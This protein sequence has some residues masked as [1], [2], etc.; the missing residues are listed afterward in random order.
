MWSTIKHRKRCIVPAEGF[1]EWLN[2]GTQKVPHYTKRADGQLMFFAGLWD[3]VHFD[4]PAPKQ[5]QSQT[6][7]TYTIITTSSSTQLRFLHDRMPVILEPDQIKTWLDPSTTRWTAALQQLL[8]PFS[9]P[10]TVYPVAREV[11]KVGNNSPSFVMPVTER[12]DG[13]KSAFGRQKEVAI[14]SS[15]KPMMTTTEETEE[16][17]VKGEEE[18]EGEGKVEEKVG[19]E[20]AKAGE[21]RGTDYFATATTTTTTTTPTAKER[22]ER[23]VKSPL[24]KIPRI[25][26]SSASNPTTPGRNLKSPKRK[27]GATAASGNKK[28]TNFFTSQTN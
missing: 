26:K 20:E 15:S 25:Y 1:Y 3:C 22:E 6:V 2:K 12:K 11:G 28:I 19:E 7:Y 4:S 27:T 16:R 13:I 14:A 9:G 8:K 21:K 17:K 5:Q 18:G 23:E 10:L 24:A